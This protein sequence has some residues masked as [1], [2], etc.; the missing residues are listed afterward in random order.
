[1]AHE[2]EGMEGMGFDEGVDDDDA[3]AEPGENTG[4]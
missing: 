4:R 1:M 2:D 3:D